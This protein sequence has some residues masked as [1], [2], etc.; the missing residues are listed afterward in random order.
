MS[1]ITF[2]GTGYDFGQTYL[3]TGLL[4]SAVKRT[5]CVDISYTIVLGSVFLATLALS[6]A[7]EEERSETNHTY[8]GQCCGLGME[9]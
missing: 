7:D 5:G 9:T 8:G 3:V 6:W 1:P 2:N 4:A